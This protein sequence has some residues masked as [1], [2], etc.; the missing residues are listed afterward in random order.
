MNKLTVKIVILISLIGTNS[1][2]GEMHD[3]FLNDGTHFR[4]EIKRAFDDGAYTLIQCDNRRINFIKSN[5]INKVQ[6]YTKA[7][8]NEV[9]N[10][11]DN[12]MIFRNFLWTDTVDDIKKKLTHLDVHRG[13]NHN[14]T[15]TSFDYDDDFMSTKIEKIETELKSCNSPIIKYT[16]QSIHEF[17]SGIKLHF[18]NYDNKTLVAVKINVRKKE[19]ENVVNSLI[20]KYG[21]GEVVDE[22]RYVKK[23]GNDVEY[24]G[25]LKWTNG[26]TILYASI[27]RKIIYYV[28]IDNLEMVSSMCHNQSIKNNKE[29]QTKI[30]QSL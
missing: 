2:A 1:F 29:A 12:E 20:E 21:E 11:S 19:I 16:T 14:G 18:S 9:L 27:Q 5:K 4:A 13:L 6:L 23:N 15:G 3:F 7:D 17:V 10:L 26:N 30:E 25:Y 8:S 22:C 28:N 24:R